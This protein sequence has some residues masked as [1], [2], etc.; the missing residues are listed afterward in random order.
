M[1]IEI[2]QKLF[3]NQFFVIFATALLRAMLVKVCK[4]PTSQQSVVI[5]GYPFYNLHT[6]G[7]M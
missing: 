7:N 6:I 4:R 5:E 3:C 1:P 2:E